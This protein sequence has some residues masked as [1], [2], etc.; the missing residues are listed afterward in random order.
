MA[1]LKMVA[2]DTCPDRIASLVGF[3]RKQTKDDPKAKVAQKDIV[4]N[5][6]M[7]DATV[8]RVMEDL[9]V[10]NIVEQVAKD[11][12][13]TRSF[14]RLTPKMEGLSKRSTLFE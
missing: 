1:A 9:K 6:N 11:M 3:V 5:T 13:E 12:G 4:A 2:L 7:S 8:S 14:Y 10:L